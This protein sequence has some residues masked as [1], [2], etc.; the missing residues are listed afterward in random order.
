MQTQILK[1][2]LIFTISYI[3]LLKC[4]L[5]SKL[6][7]EAHNNLESSSLLPM[8]PDKDFCMSWIY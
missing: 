1:S 4:C 7:N 8:Y 3:A 5:K 6:Q 2:L